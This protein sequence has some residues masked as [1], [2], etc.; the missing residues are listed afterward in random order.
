MNSGTLVAMGGWLDS[1]VFD[2]PRGMHYTR[3]NNMR[4]CFSL[5]DLESRLIDLD[6]G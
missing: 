4:L 6:Y 2:M 1:K 3:R 5:F